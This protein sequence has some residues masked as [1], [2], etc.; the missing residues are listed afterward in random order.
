MARSSQTRRLDIWMNGEKTGQWSISSVG[1][2]RFEYEKTWLESAHA[3][4]ISLSMPLRSGD[5]RYQGE[6]VES[7]FDNLI[8]DSPTIRRRL[9]S[10]FRT[11][12]DR[13]FDLLAMI[14]A[15]CIGAVQILLPDQNPGNLHSIQGKP[16]GDSEV[17]QALRTATSI[18]APGLEDDD[19]FRISLAGFQEKTALLFH[20]G[21]WNRSLGS[22][23]STHIF[24]LP[25][26]QVGRYQVDLSTSVENEWLCGRIAQAF[27]L[28]VANSEMATFEDQKV[29]IV[30]RFDR[31]LSTDG[32]WWRR[33]PQEDLC[34]ALGTPLGRKYESEGGPGIRDIETFLLG[35]IDSQ[36]DRRLFLKTQVLFWML[37]ATDGHA[38]N[39]SVFIG[40]GGQYALT[41]LYDIL[42]AYP[43]LGQ[44]RNQIP[45]QKAKMAMAVQGRARHYEWDRITR[46]HWM[47][48]ARVNGLEGEIQGMLAELTEGAA[49]VVE[50]VRRAL[51]MG[52]P[53]QVSEP[54]LEGLLSAATRL[55][56]GI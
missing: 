30:R 5:V 14:G 6:K 23:P 53:E 21:R 45:V 44:G 18:P 19:A 51:P 26:G 50:R 11:E 24:K 10:R 29:L 3:R 42:S 17:A 56:A 48:T 38:R 52:Y 46:R 9:Q 12:S 40:R 34:Q 16:L 7:F 22:T 43:I 1:Q 31:E 32:S 15:D 49:G 39:F 47:E 28:P 4:P 25:M 20:K 13:A 2:H 35:S 54:I 55:E 27:G 41:P 8:P 36:A 37:C 33:I